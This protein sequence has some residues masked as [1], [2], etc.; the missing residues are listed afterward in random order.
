MSTPQGNPPCFS[1]TT[2]SLQSNLLKAVPPISELESTISPIFVGKGYFSFGSISEF[3]IYS[4]SSCKAGWNTTEA[5][6][7]IA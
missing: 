1:R 5:E 6:D 3:E 4:N 2:M 7:P